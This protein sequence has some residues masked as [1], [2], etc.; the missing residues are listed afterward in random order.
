VPQE[1]HVSV[2]PRSEVLYC[3]VEEFLRIFSD[4]ESL[5][6]KVNALFA[7]TLCVETCEYAIVELTEAFLLPV[8]QEAALYHC[9]KRTYAKTAQFFRDKGYPPS[10]P[11]IDQLSHNFVSMATDL[12][13]LAAAVKPHCY[14]FTDRLNLPSAYRQ[15]A[16]RLQQ[17]GNEPPARITERAEEL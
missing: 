16:D 1:Q 17:K 4:K 14:F 6:L 8:L 5:L 13:F 10:T 11:S 9:E 2:P 3:I 12:V 7:V 15:L